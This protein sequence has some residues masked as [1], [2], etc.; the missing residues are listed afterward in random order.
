MASATGRHGVPR[1][2]VAVHESPWHAR[3]SSWR[4]R[5][6]PWRVRGSPWNAV[7]TAV[8]C[9]RGPWALPRRA[10]KKSNNVHLS[11]VSVTNLKFYAAEAGTNEMPVDYNA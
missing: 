5:G 9:R 4:V 1:H 11:I 10:A 6:S 7:Q 3:G 2:A 8:E